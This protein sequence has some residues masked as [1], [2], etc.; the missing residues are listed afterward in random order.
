MGT[1]NLICAVVDGEFKLANYTQWDGYIAGQGK[2]VLDFIKMTLDVPKFKTAL[3][4]CHWLTPEQE[5]ETWVK[6]GADPN[7][8]S[9][10]VPFKVADKHTEM[11]PAL[12]R[13]TGARVLELIQNGGAR[14]L[15]DSRDFANDPLFCEYAYVLDMDREVLEVYRGGYD[16]GE[17][18]KTGRFPALDL[19]A[20]MSFEDCAMDDS[21]L[22]LEKLAA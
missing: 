10:L 6:A 15:S 9:G 22:K 4:E 12:S 1:R 18:F 16:E 17:G 2:T 19:V 13:D 21:L 14:E 7:N 20:E 3:R 8:T 5:H 11:F